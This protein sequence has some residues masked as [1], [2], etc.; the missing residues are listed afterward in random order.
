MIVKYSWIRGD[1]PEDIPQWAYLY[2]IF[3]LKIPPDHLGFLQ[4][5]SKVGFLD[6][7]PVTFLRIFDPEIASKT[8][9]IKEN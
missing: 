8:M 5:V 4:T 1:G 3:T 6:G 2:L 9:M 7:R